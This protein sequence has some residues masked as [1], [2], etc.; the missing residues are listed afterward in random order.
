VKPFLPLSVVA[1]LAVLAFLGEP[2][3]GWTL[4]F[5]VVS[6]VSGGG[7][8]TARAVFKPEEA[9]EAP[10]NADTLGINPPHLPP[11][12]SAGKKVEEAVALVE[13]IIERKAVSWESAEVRLSLPG[14]S[15]TFSK[16]KTDAKPEEKPDEDEQLLGAI[17]PVK[18]G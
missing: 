17:V 15:A 6:V 2:E 5:V 9:E 14:V 13:R 4:F 16:G 12:E 10:V 7:F 8:I 18:E 3:I 11:D 1:L